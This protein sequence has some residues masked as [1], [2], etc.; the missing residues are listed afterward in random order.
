MRHILLALLS[1]LAFSGMAFAHSVQQGAI[2]IIHPHINEP[3]AGA[4]SA[5]GYMAI[6]NAGEHADRLI[7]V[8]TEAARK[9]SLHT[10]EHGGDGVARMTPL[11]A[12]TIPAGDTVVLEQGGMHMMLMGLTAPLKEGQMV[13]AVLIFET[14]GRVAV[15]FSVDPAD[16]VG[17][18]TMD[19][20][21]AD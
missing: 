8:E 16:G 10:T 13:P 12:I 19:H 5:A 1:T 3:F 4:K 15:E 18:S 21:A 20:G 11:A 2:Q 9:A 17:H 6:S 14:G 7:G